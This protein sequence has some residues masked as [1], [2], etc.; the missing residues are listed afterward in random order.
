MAMK[1]DDRMNLVIQREHRLNLVFPG[2][3][4]LKPRYLTA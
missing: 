2:V 4:P 1:Y 3:K